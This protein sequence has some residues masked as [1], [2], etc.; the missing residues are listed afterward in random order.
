VQ[1]AEERRVESTDPQR[2]QRSGD[3]ADEHREGTG[4]T[5]A[6]GTRGAQP[7]EPRGIER[8]IADADKQARTGSK[9]ERVRSTPPA[10][11]WNDTASD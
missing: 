8:G 11:A 9:D 5:G 1:A 3:A 4:R 2:A 6:E 7:E 10:G